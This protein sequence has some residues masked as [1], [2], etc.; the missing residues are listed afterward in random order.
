[1]SH[2]AELVFI[3]AEIVAEFVDDGAADLLTDFVVGGTNSFDVFLVEDDGV[4]ARRQ[5]EDAPLGRRNAAIYAEHQLARRQRARTAGAAR[6]NLLRRQVLDQHR[7]VMNAAAK[8]AGQAIQFGLD[9]L[10]EEVALHNLWYSG[11]GR[12]RHGEMCSA[13][14]LP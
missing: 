2:V 9:E 11:A 8:L 5:I 1:M 3:H 12:L 14:S 10:Q 7:D 4:R 13:W 6:F